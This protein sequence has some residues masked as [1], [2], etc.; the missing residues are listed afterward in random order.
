MA[1]TST[2]PERLDD[3]FK[4]LSHGARRRL[5]SL[6]AGRG[7]RTLQELAEELPYT[8]Q[9]V[10]QHLDVLERAG[11]VSTRRQGR[12]KLHYLNATP[13]ADAFQRVVA[14]LM[15]REA[16]ELLR[17]RDTIEVSPGTLQKRGSRSRKASG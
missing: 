17:L 2:R 10:S 16:E 14:P 11:V 15:T 13:L 4:A 1:R 9:A 8:R 3:V 5:L 6:L 12:E 7:G